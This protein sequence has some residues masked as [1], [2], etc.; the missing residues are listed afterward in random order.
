MISSIKFIRIIRT[1]NIL[2]L[3]RVMS[4]SLYLI[5]ILEEFLLKEFIHTFDLNTKFIIFLESYGSTKF[6]ATATLSFIFMELFIITVFLFFRKFL[7]KKN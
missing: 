7:K 3:F 6:Y 2:Y 5:F 4:I 1:L